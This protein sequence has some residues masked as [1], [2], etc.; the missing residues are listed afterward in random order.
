VLASV[1]ELSSP[2]RTDRLTVRV[3]KFSK[4]YIHVVSEEEIL[5]HY[6]K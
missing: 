2:L 5:V 1:N 3:W 4:C 6:K